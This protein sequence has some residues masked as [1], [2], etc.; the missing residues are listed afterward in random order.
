MIDFDEF[1]RLDRVT[2]VDSLPSRKTALQVL[3]EIIANDVSTLSYR[4]IFFKLQERE[5]QGSTVLDE[6]PVAIPHCR[7]EACPSA[8][9]TVLKTRDG[10]E[11][12]FGGQAVQLI[13]GM[14][15]PKDAPEKALEVLR[16]VVKILDDDDRLRRMLVADTPELLYPIVREGF[17]AEAS[18]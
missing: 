16:C 2:I 17:F 4:E 13:F 8:I 7:L 11:V 1:L 9:A 12:D 6:L 14:C 10:S 5:Q 15:F 18:A 3:A